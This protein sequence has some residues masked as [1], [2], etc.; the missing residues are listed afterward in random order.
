VAF[1]DE[2]DVVGARRELVAL[3][4]VLDAETLALAVRAGGG[5]GP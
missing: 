1:F 2:L 4:G 5:G 3:G